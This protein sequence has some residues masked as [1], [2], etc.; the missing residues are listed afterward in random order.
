[1]T[2]H[3]L[4]PIGGP[5]LVCLLAGCAPNDAPP[6]Q[7]E[8]YFFMNQVELVLST[9]T[10]AGGRIGLDLDGVSS[11]SNDGARCAHDD[12]T[13]AG[14]REGIDAQ[15]AKMET[16][17]DLLGLGALINPLVQDYVDEGNMSFVVGLSGVDSFENDNRVELRVVRALS[18]PLDIG[19]DGFAEPNQSFDP[20]PDYAY[21]TGEGSIRDGV[22]TFQ[23][24]GELEFPFRLAQVIGD[25]RL[26]N[27]QGEVR[28]DD[29]VVSG[30]ALVSVNGIIGG[31]ASVADISDIFAAFFAQDDTVT[32]SESFVRRVLQGFADFN[33]SEESQSCQGISVGM[34]VGLV[35]AFLLS[36]DATTGGMP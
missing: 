10:S 33:W 6:G 15:M 17:L 29:D 14:G 1:M 12:L 8:H 35:R 16:V 11:E 22:L 31:V 18:H 7:A 24:T 36:E 21:L 25:I 5:L 27:V 23:T 3:V 30:G 32:V 34:N 20:D 28:I 19:T 2:R 4:L 9:D 26:T 13:D